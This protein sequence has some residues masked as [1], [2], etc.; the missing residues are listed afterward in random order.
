MI[1]KSKK[2]ILFSFIRLQLILVNYYP[3]VLKAKT[4]G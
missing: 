4:G 2:D 3:I 1:L